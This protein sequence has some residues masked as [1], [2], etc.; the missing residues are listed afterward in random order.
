MWRLAVRHRGADSRRRVGRSD[1]AE[2]VARKSRD[3][4]QP[5]TDVRADHGADL[6]DEL[7]RAAVDLARRARPAA[8][9]RRCAWMCWMKKHVGA[10]LAPLAAGGATIRSNARPAVRTRSIGVI[11]RSIVRIGLIFSA[12]PIHAWAAPIRPPR[13]RN[14][15]VSTAKQDLHRSRAPR[16]PPRRPPAGRAARAPALSAAIAIS[17]CPAQAVARVE[18]RRCARA[19]RHARS[20]RRA[21]ARRRGTVPRDAA[22]QVDREDV[23]AAPRSAARRRRG[24]RRPRA[25]TCSAARARSAGGRRT[26]RS[27]AGRP[28]DR[29][30]PSQLTYSETSRKP[31]RSMTSRGQVLRRVGDDGDGGHSGAGAYPPPRGARGSW[32]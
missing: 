5:R 3:A 30:R 23:V 15:S 24:S 18:H 28:R 26:R 12:E 11:S 21:P 22:R 6:R 31:W 25:G 2:Q 4:D 29:S 17:P 10:L 27:R 14:S 20:A 7:G 13:R 8:R 19:R 32:T 9:R 16:A 1:R